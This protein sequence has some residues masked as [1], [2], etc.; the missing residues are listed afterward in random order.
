MDCTR[1]ELM[2]PCL[3]L[4]IRIC[5]PCSQQLWVRGQHQ[6]RASSLQPERASV[7][8]DATHSSSVCKYLH[9]SV[10]MPLGVLLTAHLHASIAS[11]S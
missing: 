8:G 4:C 6:T 7:S 2:E 3:Q 5:T 10:C 11:S 9:A 1:R